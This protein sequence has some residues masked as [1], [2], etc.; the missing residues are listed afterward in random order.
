MKGTHQG[1][2]GFTHSAA[3]GSKQRAACRGLRKPDSPPAAGFLS[4]LFL[5]PLWPAAGSLCS[6]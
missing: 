2:R 6:R 5:L 1:T 4:F 3:V